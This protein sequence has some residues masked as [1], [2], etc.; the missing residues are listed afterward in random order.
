M[1]TDYAP[2]IEPPDVL[3]AQARADGYD[4]PRLRAV[5]NRVAPH[6]TDAEAALL[7]ACLNNATI[8]LDA[9]A[10]LD[11]EDF[12]D[13]GHAHIAAAA[14]A[15]HADGA[16]VDHTTVTG[17]LR[18][19]GT[20]DLIGGGENRLITLLAEGAIAARAPHH[21][22]T[23]AKHARLRQIA[24]IGAEITATATA[25]GAEPG[26]A[27]QAAQALID[28][29]LDATADD[30]R[31]AVIGDLLDTYL[32]DLEER[33]AHG[34]ATG[35]TCGL[36]NLDTLTGGFRPGTLTTIAGRP[37]TGKSDVACHIARHAADAG[38]VL[39]VSIEM[40]RTEMLHRWV[41]AETGIAA[42]SLQTGELSPSQWER[43][44]PALI[45]LSALPLHIEDDPAATAATI[46]AAQRRTG[47]RLVIVDYLQIVT[48]APS[49]HENRQVEVSGIVASLK[50]LARQTEVPVIALA[51][52]NRSM[53]NRADKRP[54][55]SDLRESGAIEQDS[56]VV[57]GL[58]REEV[59]RPDTDQRG[60]MEALVLKNRHGATG[61]ARLAYD[62]ARKTIH[63]LA[64]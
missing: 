44:G 64:D 7:G 25:P 48:A 34:G 52:L 56:D 38:P 55:L 24:T 23:I 3:D 31:L 39:V 57:I 42:T 58:Y 51:Q 29:A 26:A 37:G 12:Y 14:Q 15:L 49:R 53:E 22:A 2:E 63:P 10:G 40:S 36:P 11:P 30:T 28:Q 27:A 43:V 45:A 47:A 32:D 18:H 4:A 1:S 16:P 19:H 50:R 8:A 46:R 41:A 13:P 21:A 9:L 59:H 60:V 35:I 61:K 6:D 62:A 54:T 20:L 33:S 17:H 5:P